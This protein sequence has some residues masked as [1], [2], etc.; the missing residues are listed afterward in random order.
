MHSSMSFE[1]IATGADHLAQPP[2]PPG[3]H[4][5]SAIEIRPARPADTAALRDLAGLDSARPLEGDTLVAIID[6]APV[7]ALSLTDGRVVADPF[8]RTAETVEMLK[9]RAAGHG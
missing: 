7:A 4:M 9:L 8:R 1:L 5:S 6:E 3:A 2:P